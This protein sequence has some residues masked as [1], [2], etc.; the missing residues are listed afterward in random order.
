VSALTSSSALLAAQAGPCEPTLRDFERK[1]VL[2]GQVATSDAVMVTAPSASIWPMTVRWM[3]DDGQVVQAGDKVAEFDGSQLLT[4]VDALEAEVKTASNNLSAELSRAGS[5][6]AD[7]ELEVAQKTAA[8]DRA[9]VEARLPAELVP[10]RDLAEKALALERAELEAKNAAAKLA[11]TRE[12]QRASIA[13]QELALGKARSELAEV[14]QTLEKMVVRSPGAGVFSAAENPREQRLVQVGDALWAGFRIGRIPS[15]AGWRVEAQLFDVDDGKIATGQPVRA[16]LD[17]DPERELHGK[18][19]RVDQIA[20]ELSR[21]SPRRAFQ[22]LV[23]IDE[24]APDHGES[25]VDRLRP[26]M[27][28]R[29]EV[30]LAESRQVK[31]LPRRCLAAWPPEQ[32]G[33]CSAQ[34]CEVLA[35]AV[36]AAGARP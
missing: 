1:W 21:N 26:G 32:I 16:F 36:A 17:A 7:L 24:F 27:S 5:E 4:R 22:V 8:R 14:R 31:V 2:T 20:Q 34:E 13:M 30:L 10:A 6:L 3:V 9:V 23:T 25:L 11:G 15:T 28:V 33:E 12:A 35:T 29:V 18:V 19:L